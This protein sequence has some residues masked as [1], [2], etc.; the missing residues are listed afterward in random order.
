MEFFLDS[1]NLEEIRQATE[2]G[3]IAGVT[4]NPSL[5]AREDGAFADLLPRIAGVVDGPVSAEVIGT[6]TET[7]ITE[8]VRLAAVA[9]NVVIKI[10][11]T[12]EGLKAVKILA[13]RGIKT[14]VTLIF[15]VTQALLAARAGGTY[16]SPFI[17]RLDD[18]GHDGM[19]VVRDTAAIFARH[20]IAAEIIAASIRHPRHVVEAAKAGAHIATVPFKLIEQMIRHPLTELG[21]EKFLR[22]WERS[23][24]KNI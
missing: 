7:M 13:G 2:I 22:D 1:A 23:G 4:T 5:V 9:P 6:T 20:G 24:G 8:A 12:L 14:N 19:E 17:G 16:V 18:I 21:L 3:V 10:P 11:L 15:S